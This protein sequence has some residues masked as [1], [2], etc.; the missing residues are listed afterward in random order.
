MASAHAADIRG[1]Q[2]GDAAVRQNPEGHKPLIRNSVEIL[3]VVRYTE[4][5]GIVHI[6]FA[7]VGE[8][9]VFHIHIK[10]CNAAGLPVV[11]IGAHIGHIFLLHRISSCPL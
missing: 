9:A 10:H 2:A 6:L 7:A 11:R 8:T 5:C 4:P 3:S 1:I